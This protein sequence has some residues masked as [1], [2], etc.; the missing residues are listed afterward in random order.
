MLRQILAADF[1]AASL[2]LLGFFDFFPGVRIDIQILARAAGSRE[3]YPYEEN[4]AA[5]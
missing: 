4:G 1:T 5:E 2:T 3:H